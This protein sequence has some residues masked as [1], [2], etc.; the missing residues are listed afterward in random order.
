MY[1][2][3]VDTSCM[4]LKLQVC[5]YLHS[6]H[7]GSYAE[8]ASICY[9]DYYNIACGMCEKT[10]NM[11]LFSVSRTR[12]SLNAML[13]DLSGMVINDPSSYCLEE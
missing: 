5:H 9:S 12:M 10:Y 13:R 7:Q 4:R 8:V 2:K 3:P 11:L 6:G 1:Y